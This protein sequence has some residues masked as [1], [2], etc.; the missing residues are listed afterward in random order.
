VQVVVL[1]D[2]GVLRLHPRYEPPDQVS[3][4]GIVARRRLEHFGR[5]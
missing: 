1:D 3:L 5:A 2:V 4:G